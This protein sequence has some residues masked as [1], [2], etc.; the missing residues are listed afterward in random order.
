MP[1]DPIT[2]AIDVG[3]KL[4]DK[5]FPNKEE[6]RKHKARMLELQQQGEFKEL[7]ERMSVIRAEAQSK[8]PWTSRA[9]PTFL[10]TFYFILLGLTIVAPTVG[11]FAPAEMQAFYANVQAGFDAVPKGLWW[12]FTSGFLGYGSLRTYE[13]QKGVAK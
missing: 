11:V 9:R 3:G 6:A 7:E 12:T 10:Y 2:A 5:L 1:L 8:D 4:I 13:K